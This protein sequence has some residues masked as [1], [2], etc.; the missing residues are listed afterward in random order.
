MNR[1]TILLLFGGESSEHDVS[2]MSACNIYQAI[3]Q[4]K[5]DVKLGYIT[6]SGQDWLLIDSF[7][8]L[9]G[10]EFLPMLGRGYV[11]TQKNEI[12]IDYIFPALHGKNGEDGTVQGLV[13]LL[14]LPVVGPDLLSAS[15]TMHKDMSKRLFEG[16]D[17]PVVPWT[18]RRAYEPALT[19]ENVCRA[20]RTDTVFVK[21]NAAGSSVGVTRVERS[22]Q[23]RQALDEAAT[24]DELVL[25]EKALDVREI[26][27]AVLG[28]GETL[29]VS[30]AGE[31]LPG[32]EFYTYED[33][34][35][36]DTKSSVAIPADISSEQLTQLQEYARRA[37][38]AVEGRGM[39]RVDFFIDRE[40]G[41]IYLNEI[42]SIPGFTNNSM[43]PKLWQEA[44]LSYE[45]L[46]STLIENAK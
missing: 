23:W 2:I 27:L 13:A 5:Y 18:S 6:R 28:S 11:K 30:G 19:F 21:P 14:H 26:E 3:D 10:P 1:Q 39:A 33:K 35:A 34:Y 36:S 8:E 43:Y 32:E 44:G 12:K 29:R 9:N 25:I 45:H 24:H 42:N 4:E 16:V 41:E 7:D 15:V 37:Y 38:Q 46:V 20:L 31:I 22:D 40:N 17:I